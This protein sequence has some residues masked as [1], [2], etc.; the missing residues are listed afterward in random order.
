MELIDSFVP[1]TL[2]MW[3]SFENVTQKKQNPPKKVV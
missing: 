1:V 3:R 2:F